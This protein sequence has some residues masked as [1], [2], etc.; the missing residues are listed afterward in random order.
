MKTSINVRWRYILF[1]FLLAGSFSCAS[2]KQAVPLSFE[3]L[4]AVYEHEYSENGPKAYLI[5]DAA[6][7]QAVLGE[8]KIRQQDKSDYESYWKTN[9]LL[10]V[11]GGTRPSSGFSLSTELVTQKGDSLLIEAILTKPGNNCMVSD[12]IT[13]PFQLIAIPRTSQKA[14][15]ALQLKEKEKACQ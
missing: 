3:Y 10:L 12:M 4:T 6:Q 14:V 2:R 11:Y 9:S 13:Y 1:S 5:N 7:Y 8:L 15:P